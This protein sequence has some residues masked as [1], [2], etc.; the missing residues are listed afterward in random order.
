ME[1]GGYHADP[2]T[3]TEITNEAFA[4]ASVRRVAHGQAVLEGL[5]AQSLFTDDVV[6]NAQYDGGMILH[7]WCSMKE[8]VGAERGSRTERTRAQRNPSG[9]PTVNILYPNPRGLVH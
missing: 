8:A 3:T 7:T 4:G 9:E 1:L 2:F 5:C 6:L